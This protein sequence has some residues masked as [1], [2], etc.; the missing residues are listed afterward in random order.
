MLGKVEYAALDKYVSEL[1]QQKFDAKFILYII[2]FAVVVAGVW[3]F[4]GR[5]PK[6]KKPI[7]K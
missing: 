5:K 7:S 3:W 1:G 4:V 6:E 2:L